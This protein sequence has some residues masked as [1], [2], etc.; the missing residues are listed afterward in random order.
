MGTV[1]SYTVVHHPLHRDMSAVVPYV[2]GSSGSMVPRV[3]A[4]GC[5]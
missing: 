3:K 1:Y 2:S 4:P 5:S